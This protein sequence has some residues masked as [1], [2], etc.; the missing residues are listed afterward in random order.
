MSSSDAVYSASFAITDLSQ[1][2]Q[3]ILEAK[4]TERQINEMAKYYG[5]TQ[6]ISIVNTVILTEDCTY[7][8]SFEL[9]YK[10]FLNTLWMTV[11]LCLS[12]PAKKLNKLIPN[13]NFLDL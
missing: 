13:S 8:T 6:F 11:A 10:N 9:M 12:H 4:N 2:I 3:I 1:I 5:I 7:F